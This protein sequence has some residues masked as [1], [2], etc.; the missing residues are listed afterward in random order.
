MHLQKHF[1]FLFPVVGIILLASCTNKETELMLNQA[2]DGPQ[3]YINEI[4]TWANLNYV[5]IYNNSDK[6]ITVDGWQLKTNCSKIPVMHLHGKI[7]TKSFLTFYDSLS[8]FMQY[9]P[10]AQS[11]SFELYNNHDQLV[12]RFAIPPLPENS[13]FGRCPDGKSG[14]LF[15]NYPSANLPNCGTNLPPFFLNLEITPTNPVQF[16]NFS[17][18]VKVTDDEMINSVKLYYII[19]SYT[20]SITMVNIPCTPGT[21]SINRVG[22][23]AGTEMKYYIKAYDNKGLSTTYPKNAPAQTKSIIFQ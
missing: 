5:E 17:I 10:T 8:T 7:H 11:I 1:L 2:A 23:S 16:E 19:N 3:L 14:T 9:L 15:F 20:D 12:D 4:S 22:Y 6:G 18:L 13:F 21:Y